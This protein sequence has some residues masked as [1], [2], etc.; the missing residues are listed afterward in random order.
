M[1]PRG[2][3][4]T[5]EA[6]EP[7]SLGVD[8]PVAL[9]PDAAP[10]ARSGRA[11]AWARVAIACALLLG[12]AAVQWAQDRQTRADLEEG[13]RRFRIDLAAIPLKMGSWEGT[14]TRL[15]PI[16]SRGTGADQ[17]VT[18]RYVDE[19]T[20]ATIELILL[21]GPAVD[22]YTHIPD[23]CYPAAGFTSVGESAT[24]EVAAGPYH[25]PFRTY[26]Y[27]KGE[28]AQ[29]DLQEV[30]YSWRRP[31][32]WSPDVATQKVFERIPSMYKVQLARRVTDRERRDV[33]N[34]CEAFLRELLPRIESRLAGVL[35][36]AGVAGGRPATS[37][38]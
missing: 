17:V 13:R 29:T 21:Y 3:E 33:G 8:S 12:S 11:A 1:T 2:V 18:R 27:S 7:M 36:A 31:G 19:N 9:A 28:G 10:V 20:G 6:V 4:Q 37:G 25:A 14:D 23:A 30:Y 22:M 35:P 34:P 16:I 5:P 38:G 15:D 26:V 32:G 24:R